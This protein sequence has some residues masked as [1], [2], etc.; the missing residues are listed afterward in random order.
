[1]KITSVTPFLVG[2]R[3]S[4]DGWSR[5]QIMIFVKLTTDTGLVGWG[6]AYA[7][8]FRQRAVVEIIHGLSGPLMAMDNA[9]PRGFLHHVGR[10]FSDE[11]PGIDYASAVSA[12]EIA[13]WD[14]MGKSTGL[15]LHALLGGTL[16]DKVPL[17]A[18]AWDEPVQTAEAVAARCGMMRAQGYRAVKIYPLRR[19]TLREAEDCVRLTREAIGPDADML[20]DFAVQHDRRHAL[21]AAQLFEQYNP[22]WIEEPVPGDDLPSMAD[23][24]ARISARVTTGE[25]QA[26]LRHYRDVLAAG[27]ADVLNPDIAGAGGILEMLNIGAMAHAH[28]VQISPH[29][30]NST[31]VAF[32]AMLHVFAVMPNAT[33]AEL[34]YDY[35]ELGAT[36]ARCDYVIRDG[37][38]SLPQ[39]PGLGVEMDE[40]ALRGLAV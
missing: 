2:A 31:T 19:S 24:R 3:P 5:G 18:N 26:G 10:G 39:V 20:L 17:Y 9:T 7:L 1:M 22:Y 21:R 30:W 15:P 12:I 33:Y 38:A 27:A 8:T 14:L 4:S 37:F 6:E 25:R 35:L 11:H 28:G 34:Y 36:F 13:L 23:L 16:V 29:S 32:L 40:E